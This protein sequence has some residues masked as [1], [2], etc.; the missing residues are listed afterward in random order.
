MSMS[1]TVLAFY[2]DAP[3]NP[4]TVGQSACMSIGEPISPSAARGSMYCPWIPAEYD[5]KPDM[6]CDFALHADPILDMWDPRH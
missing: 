3:L 2:M 5:A 1:L 4:G 6:V